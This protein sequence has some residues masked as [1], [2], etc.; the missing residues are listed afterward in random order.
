MYGMFYLFFIRFTHGIGRNTYINI[1]S[2]ED[3]L[4]QFQFWKRFFILFINLNNHVQICFEKGE[5]ILPLKMLQE[6][7]YNKFVIN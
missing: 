2:W 7:L 6:N 3:R 1:L 5:K 4:L